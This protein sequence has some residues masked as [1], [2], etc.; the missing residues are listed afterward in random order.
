MTKLHC[1]VTLINGTALNYK[2]S[3]DSIKLASFT[4][5]LGLIFIF[6]A[7]ATVPLHAMDNYYLGEFQ[8]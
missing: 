1:S 8:H 5:V 2:D 6:F 4:F 7:F 3:V